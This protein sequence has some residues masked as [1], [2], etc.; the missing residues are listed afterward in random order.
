MNDVSAIPDGIH[1]SEV[2]LGWLKRQFV[3]KW[4]EEGLSVAG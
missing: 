3:E 4:M 2:Q 1:G